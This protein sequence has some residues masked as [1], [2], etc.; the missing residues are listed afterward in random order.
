MVQ[1]PRGAGS[2][3]VGSDLGAAAAVVVGR[4]VALD[5]SDSPVSA[6]GAT[7]LAEVLGCDG[8]VVVLVDGRADGGWV[9]LEVGALVVPDGLTLGAPAAG[10]ADAGGAAAVAAG[11]R[12][13]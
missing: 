5:A 2:L 3:V 13:P 9:A 11:H 8:P 6:R 12:V 7:V 4:V 1:I 10:A